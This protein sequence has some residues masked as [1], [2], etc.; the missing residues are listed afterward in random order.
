MNK[1][2]VSG[3][4]GRDAELKQ[5]PNGKYVLEFSL[6]V[7]DGFGENK[8][9]YWWKC[10]LW[11]ERAVKLAEHFRKGT[12]LLIE[13]R[14]ALREYEKKDGSKG[15]SAEIFV[16]DFEFMGGKKESNDNHDADSGFAPTDDDSSAVP[17]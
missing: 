14:P 10:G 13:G 12:K 3:G 17:F 4:L 9:T 6:A 1:I 5:T 8:K 7:N 16:T 15:V 11:G 2:L